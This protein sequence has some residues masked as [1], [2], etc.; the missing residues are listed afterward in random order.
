M[1]DIEQI[2]IYKFK[3][4]VKNFEDCVKQ[5]RAGQPLES[6]LKYHSI[7]N[8]GIIGKWWYSEG[9]SKTKESS[10]IPWISFMNEV[11][12]TPITI[13][14]TN[15]YPRGLLLYKVLIQNEYNYFAISF[16]LGGDKNIN[17]NKVIPDFGIKVAMNICDPEEIKSIQ[18][19][20]HEAISIQ[21]EKQILSGAGLSVFN[22]DYNDE[23]FRRIIGKTKA[24]YNYISS[25][26]GGEKIQLKF[27]KDSPL[28]WDSIK[29]IT[30]ELN[31]LYNSES[32]KNTEFKSFDNWSFEKEEEKIKE[33]NTKLINE[34][35]NGNFD[36]ISL[37]VP[38]FIDIN[39]TSFKYKKDEQE[40]HEELDFIEYINTL[41]SH[42]VSL[43]GLQNRNIFIYDK[44][45]ETIYSKW[46]IF[47]CIIAEIMDQDGNCYILY[48]G[49]WRKISTDFKQT[50]TNYL[51]NNNIKFDESILTNEL[52]NN[53][54]IYNSSLNQNREELFNKECVRCSENLFLFDKSKI[55]IAQEKIYEICDILTADKEL[56]H[57]KKYKTGASS[58]S[59]LFTQAK[60][61]SEAIIINTDTRKTMVDFIEQ[62]SN[63]PLSI[64][65][66]KNKEIFK[67]ILPLNGRLRESDFT[68]VLCILTKENIQLTDLPFMTQYEISKMD[69]YLRR[70]RGFNVKYINRKVIMH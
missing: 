66:G 57:V 12:E 62:D 43:S 34:I 47:Q 51:N 35:N 16:G 61:Y 13:A 49:L 15:T 44:V 2:S 41:R 18:T 70:N 19:S 30:T 14:Y 67:E 6:F 29:H 69:D 40:D 11:L 52:K 45:T 56:I 59:H 38:E 64:N 28:T 10:N 9:D 22:I 53:I 4:S 46:K 5:D 60:L 31:E 50:V 63:N 17:K 1:A 32:Y 37:C 54:N 7:D 8:N 48:N 65:N 55:D 24:E 25:V 21:S 58:M 39:K 23:F 26:T 68:V 27:S 3:E 42:K 20:Q 36:K 33:L